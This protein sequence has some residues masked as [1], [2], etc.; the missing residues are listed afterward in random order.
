LAIY[1]VVV[2]SHIDNDIGKIIKQKRIF[3]NL[4]LTELGNI[5]NVSP[6]HLARIERRERFPSAKVLQKIA[7]P[8]GFSENELFM[9]AGFL[10]EP[11]KG[12]LD[13]NNT[14]HKLRQLDPI[15]AQTLASESIEVQRS[16][17]GILKLLKSVA[18]SLV[19]Q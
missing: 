11:S 8:L 6:S 13:I 19:G 4:T 15:V 14:E 18:R 7:K 17:I 16:V 9:I 3:S 1:N 5:A 12:E 10:S 2:V